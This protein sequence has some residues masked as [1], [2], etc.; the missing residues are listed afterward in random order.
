MLA[1]C[2]TVDDEM[3][4]E[5]DSLASVTAVTNIARGKP[6]TASAVQGEY[7]SANAL[8][9]D[10]T[11]RW[12]ST[13][14]DAQWIYVDLGATY[15]I[16]KVK[17]TWERAFATGYQIQVS[18][19]AS[20]WT[21]IYST[22]T[23]DGGVDDLAGLSGVGR[24]VRMNGTA[25]AT[26]WGF[27]L[28]E[29]EV[30][31]TLQST[32]ANLALGRPQAVSSTE[33]G[34]A[35]TNAVDGNP[36]TRWSST[37]S[38]PQWINVDLGTSHTINRVK[39]TWEVAYGKG[40][41]VQVSADAATWATIYSV[42][43]GD[44]GIDDLTGLSASGRYVRIYGTERGTQWGYSLWERE[45]YGDGS[46]G[47]CIPTTCAAQAKTCGTI[48]DG[49][50]GTLSCGDSC[51]SD[52]PP[53]PTS[54]YTPCPSDGT[55]CKIMPLG[56]SITYGWNGS[57][58]GG[59]RVELF[60]RALQAGQDITFVGA[61]SSG[62][63]TVDGVAFPR[64]NEGYVGYTIYDFPNVRLGIAGLTPKEM[65]AYKPNII[66]LMIGTNDILTGNDVRNAPARLASLIDTII[67]TDSN[68]LLVVATVTPSQDDATNAAI[69]AYNAAIPD[70][71]AAR[72]A[73]GKHVILVDMHSA[74]ASQPNYKTQALSD[75]VH[76]NDRGFVLM[77]DAWYDAIAGY[78]R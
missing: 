62:P 32:S 22:T 46:S 57:Y 66:T 51:S 3:V 67:A 13:F 74:I 19:N 6:A 54:G 64:G 14:A 34:Y 70:I 63:N 69:N 7:A 38:D 16:S 53:P 45:V 15:N 2:G 9:G 43:D 41:L 28:W 42:T 12:S 31:G 24:Y 11:T 44:G 36:D 5:L 37:F 65:R 8:D 27:S 40:Y 50:G 30:Y 1:A 21:T 17:L 49:C 18:P 59:Y 25:R 33:P 20:T 73:A 10:G 35:S 39:L 78:L 52:D 76:P 75:I 48:A 60:H 61:Q 29:L 77:G 68:V 58:Y 47:V 56:D 55:P 71:V 23:S 4:S 72:S 26:Q